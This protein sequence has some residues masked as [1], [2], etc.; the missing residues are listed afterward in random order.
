M[1]RVVMPIYDP[2]GLV[3]YI[4]IEAKIILREAWRLLAEWDARLGGVIQRRWTEWASHLAR[5]KE[6]VV[7][8]WCGTADEPVELHV[9]VDASET[10]ICAACYVVQRGAGKVIRALV[11]SKCLVAP[12]K[13]KSIPRLELD[14][15]VLGVRVAGIVTSAQP[16]TVARV[17]YWLDAKDVLWWLRSSTRRYTPY[18]ANR[19]SSI[20]SQSTVDQWRW[21]PT[22]ANP[23]DWRTKWVDHSGDDD[24]WWRGP[25][26]LD[27]GED[28]WPDFIQEPPQLLELCPTIMIQEETMARDLTTLIPDVSRF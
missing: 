27:L 25:E 2:L 24:L 9:Y 10:A 13:T 12:L 4:V 8:R 14:A 6:I 3:S 20:L 17:V 28:E 16:W 26:Y 11:M 21:T 19:V 5:L 15:A 18:V 7:K 1:L 23:A 22:H